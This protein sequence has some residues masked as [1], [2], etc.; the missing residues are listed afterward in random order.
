M[1]GT[2]SMVYLSVLISSAVDRNVGLSP[3]LVK[4]MTKKWYFLLLL[5]ACNI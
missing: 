3:D 4:L 5:S 2:V 1:F